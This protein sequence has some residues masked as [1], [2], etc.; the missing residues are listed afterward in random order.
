[1]KTILF[2][3]D[4]AQIPPVVMSYLRMLAH[5]WQARVVV[6][7]AFQ[8]LIA[9]GSLPAF[10]D[11]ALATP[12][13]DPTLTTTETDLETISQQRLNAVV[14]MLRGGD[15]DAVADWRLGSVEAEVV[16]AARQFRPDL[17]LVHQSSATGLFDRL[18]GSS[19]DDI[20]REA[21]CPVLFIPGAMPAEAEV[22]IR[23][24]VYVLQQN[25]TQQTV[26]EQTAPVVDAFEA[27]L[28]VVSPND[29]DAYKPDLYILQRRETG[30]LGS[31]LGSDPTEKLLADSRVPVLVYH[32]T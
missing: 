13:L 26:S 1:M 23:S 18:V 10:A 29:I 30:F 25:I 2:P 20:A 16:A 14:E 21:S 19:A 3:T 7:H 15:L 12:Y 17:L 28:T 8:P 11:P 27:H 9:A 31:L 5:R 6:L 4:L 32:K 22:H 24:V